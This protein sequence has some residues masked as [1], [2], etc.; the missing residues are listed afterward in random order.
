MR[1]LTLEKA[2]LVV[3]D[4]EVR[5]ADQGVHGG[6]PMATSRSAHLG[7]RLSISAWS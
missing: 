5:R 6:R 2:G 7:I 4:I 1:S 3:E